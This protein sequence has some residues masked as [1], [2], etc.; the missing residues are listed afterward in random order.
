MTIDVKG[1][2]GKT[3]T[4][5][6]LDSFFYWW[7]PTEYT[8]PKAYVMSL[9]YQNNLTQYQKDASGNGF[10]SHILFNGSL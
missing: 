9:T 3:H 8:G 2:D 6:Y 7:G 10:N 1:E 4:Y 5:K